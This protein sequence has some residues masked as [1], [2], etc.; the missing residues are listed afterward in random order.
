MIRFAN[1]ALMPTTSMVQAAVNTNSS[2]ARRVQ[3]STYSLA[4]R[5]VRR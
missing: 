1:A 3:V 5:W 2:S 4:L